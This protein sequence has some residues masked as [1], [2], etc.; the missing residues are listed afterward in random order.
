MTGILLA[1]FV[2]MNWFLVNPGNHDAKGLMTAVQEIRVS[3][4]ETMNLYGSLMKTDVTNTNFLGVILKEE[5]AD[6]S[7]TV[8]LIYSYSS[9]PGVE[10][11]LFLTIF[12]LIVEQEGNRLRYDLACTGMGLY[13]WWQKR[14][15]AEEHC[16]WA[17]WDET[18]WKNAPDLW[19]WLHV[20]QKRHIYTLR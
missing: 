19:K 6:S 20:P 11:T 8:S 1:G 7:G 4:G 17:P 12:S 10:D 15:E 13:V 14:G 5:F 9:T 3:F 16:A 2:S 18:N